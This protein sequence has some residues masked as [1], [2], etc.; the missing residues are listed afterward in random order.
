MLSLFRL[1][2]SRISTLHSAANSKFLLSH[3]L[4]HDNRVACGLA[5]LPP[6]VKLH[7]D[8]LNKAH[9]P[10]GQAGKLI[11]SSALQLHGI[12]QG[13]SCSDLAIQAKT[14]LIA[15]SIGPEYQSRMFPLRSSLIEDAPTP[16]LETAWAPAW[17]FCSLT[18]FSIALEVSNTRY[19]YR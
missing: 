7:Q 16:K 3:L 6:R 9:C 13:H 11:L 19:S 18:Y 15:S 8:D 14:I 17:P 4:I 1:H 12:C 2:L 5:Q 10:L